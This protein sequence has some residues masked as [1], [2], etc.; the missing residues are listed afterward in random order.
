MRRDEAF[1]R[2]HLG[3]IADA[4]D[5]GRVAQRDRGQTHRL[6]FLDADHD[7]LRS[8][9]LAEAELPVDDGDDGRV[10]DDLD[11]LVAHRLGF[12][13]PAQ[14]DGHADHAMA[15]VPGKIGADEIGG[16]ACRLGTR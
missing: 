15:V 14:I 9:R 11:A 3:E 12:L 16:D 2:R 1:G 8:D 5:M 10:R 13:E 6:A 4:T 7:R